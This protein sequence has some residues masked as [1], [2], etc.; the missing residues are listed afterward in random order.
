VAGGTDLKKK[1]DFAG[2]KNAGRRGWRHTYPFIWFPAKLPLGGIS[3]P[4]V[5]KPSYAQKENLLVGGYG[6]V[7]FKVIYP[8]GVGEKRTDWFP[9]IGQ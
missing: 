2:K 5:F 4:N 7:I 8:P 6:P 3:G 9:K 1:P